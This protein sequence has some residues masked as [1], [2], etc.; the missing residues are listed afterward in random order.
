MDEEEYFQQQIDDIDNTS[1]EDSED[2][3]TN[4]IGPNVEDDWYDGSLP[5]DIGDFSY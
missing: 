1:S 4:D 2:A 3:Y 5:S